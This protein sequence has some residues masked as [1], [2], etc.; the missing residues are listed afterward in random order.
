MDLP[1]YTTVSRT[2]L[3]DLGSANYRM[4]DRAVV[5]DQVMRQA[6]E[7]ADQ[8]LFRDLLYRL[9]NGQSTLEDW[10]HLM[11]QTPAELGDVTAF[12]EALRLFPTTA[13]VAEYNVDKLRASGEPI[14]MIKAIHA[15]PGASKASSDDA[16]GLEPVVCI[17]HGARMMLTANLWVS[18][19]LVNGAMGTVVAICYQDGKCPPDLPVVVMVRFDSYRGP[20]LPDGTVP[21]SPMRRT[22]FATTQQ[23]SRFQLPLQLAWAVTIHKAQG[24][25]LIRVVINVGK[26]EFCSGL[27]FVACSRV[28]HLADLLFVPP[29][30]YQRL[31]GLSQNRRLQE[32]LQEDERLKRMSTTRSPLPDTGSR[33][34]SAAGPAV[35]QHDEEMMV[36]EAGVPGSLPSSAAALPPADLTKDSRSPLPNLPTSEAGCDDE[37]HITRVDH[38]ADHFMYH[39]VDAEWQQRTCK[40]LG[41]EY[42]AAN[43]VAPGG[44]Q[45]SLT[46]PVTFRPIVGDGNCLFRALSFIITGSEEQ[47]MPLRQVIIRHMRSIG[48]L[49]WETQIYPDE[50]Y[51]QGMEQYIARTRMEHAG[52]W[53]TQVEIIALAHLLTTPILTHAGTL[54][55]NRYSPSAAYGSLDVSQSDC[56]QMAM[57]IRH[58]SDHYDVVTSVEPAIV[59]PAL[60]TCH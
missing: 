8:K 5:L 7:D 42:V 31:A 41:L 44:P 51:P 9:R 37:V 59:P 26:K 10:G 24:M 18:V 32:R 11:R 15:G 46:P 55:W 54:G 22:W 34:T 40:T 57:Y 2:E 13:A 6:G 43:G 30:P 27:M 35:S 48:Q 60:S 23:C 56:H 50:D 33:P 17:A 28:R 4:F 29:F 45:V 47:H 16:G 12:E 14:A 20:T 38:N 39:P 52:A 1:L 58:G 36:D 21:I 25:T 53:G 49:L 3:S 19:G